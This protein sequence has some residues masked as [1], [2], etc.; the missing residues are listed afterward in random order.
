MRDYLLSYGQVGDF[1][2]FRPLQALELDRGDLAVIQTWRG[3]EMGTVLCP[4]TEGHAHFLPNTTLG[5][6]LRAA[7]PRDRAAAEQMLQRG[8]Q[9]LE[10]GNRLAADLQLPLEV[11]EV[12]VLLD[13]QQAI[14]EYLMWQEC[15]LRP[16]VSRLSTQFNVQV[17]LHDL[18]QAPSAA[19][20]EA[21]GCGRPGCG[22]SAGGC[23]SCASGG[24]SSC[25]SVKEQT[26][27]EYFSELRSQ[28]EISPRTPLL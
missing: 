12:E 27:R 17:R 18:A 16:F 8:S 19:E 4:A 7:E 24:C 22:K 25:G 28:M 9:L 10:A 3:L 26:V 5:Q 13:G 14:V 23:T 21:E 2:R 6:I 20:E 1:G 15:D 11:L